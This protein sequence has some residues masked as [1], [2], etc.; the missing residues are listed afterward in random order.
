MR[1]TA[2]YAKQQFDKIRLFNQGQNTVLEKLTSKTN[3]INFV[4]TGM[5]FTLCNTASVTLNTRQDRL[6][7]IFNNSDS[8]PGKEFIAETN[9]LA[10]E[11]HSF[12]KGFRIPSEADYRQNLKRLANFIAFYS[13]QQIP[14]DIVAMYSSSDLKS[15][16]TINSDDLIDN[17]TTRVPVVLCLDVSGSMSVNGK[18]QELNRGV[19]EFFNAIHNDEIAK[20]SV[21][22]CIVTFNSS[23][24]IVLDFAGI[25]RQVEQFKHINL[26]ASGNTTMGAAV[27]LALDLLDKRKKE[28][29][30][31]GVD[32]WQ[33]WLVLMTDGQP[34]DSITTAAARTTQLIENKK[35]TIFPIGI[36][37]GANMLRLKQFSPKLNPLRL[38]GLMIGEFFDWLGKS[39]KTT[40]QSSPGSRIKLP[41]IDWAYLD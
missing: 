41:P 1:L 24:K 7:Y 15:T 33:P 29:Q 4:F 8:N 22:L 16:L 20:F 5:L 40:S 27:N 23:V 3:S 30:D 21:E 9:A 19:K 39:V 25:E 28:Y 18:I 17:P 12:Y 36:G 26:T 31:K 6:Q 10:K 32:Y 35:L 13:N 37:D 11:L 34:T 38:K 14:D 2:S